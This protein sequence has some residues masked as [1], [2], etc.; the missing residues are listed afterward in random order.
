MGPTGHAAPCE[1]V[2]DSLDRCTRIWFALPHGRKSAITSIGPLGKVTHP[3]GASYRSL[4]AGKKVLVTKSKNNQLDWITD[5]ININQ[6]LHGINALLLFDNDS[7]AYTTQE[8]LQHLAVHISLDVLCL[9]HLPYP[10]GPGGGISRSLL[11]K[12][13]NNTPVPWDSDYLNYGLLELAHQRFLPDASQVISC[14][15]DEIIL[16]ENGVSISDRLD[17]SSSK[18]LNISGSIIQRVTPQF[19]DHLEPLS[20]RQDISTFFHPPFHAGGTS[21]SHK[22][23]Y[24]E[25]GSDQLD[26]LLVHDILR[27]SNGESMPSPEQGLR[28]RHF[29]HVTTGWKGLGRKERPAFDKE[30]HLFDCAF[31]KAMASHTKNMRNYIYP[32]SE[33]LAFARGVGACPR[34]I[35]SPT[36]PQYSAYDCTICPF[37]T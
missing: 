28:F 20:S 36:A 31:V 19:I 27:L 4:F 14:D 29:Q 30:K 33:I 3:I 22:W 12:A 23:C 16:S 1:K 2:I 18:I 21:G 11:C 15:I 24:S 17:A 35:G 6:S 37:N 10:F 5:W 7:T 8:L 34:P 32:L 26:Q 25:G 13:N 9:V